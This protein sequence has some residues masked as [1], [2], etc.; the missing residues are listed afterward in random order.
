MT[1]HYKDSSY[2]DD[3]TLADREHQAL[4]MIAETA[5]GLVA[6]IPYDSNEQLQP[7]WQ[8]LT[9]WLAAWHGIKDLIEERERRING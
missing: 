6:R 1:T 5:R 2:R 3:R 7:R 9:R 4:V 8:A